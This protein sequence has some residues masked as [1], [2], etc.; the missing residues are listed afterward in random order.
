MI[1]LSGTATIAGDSTAA[2][3]DIATSGLGSLTV[4]TV[5][6]GTL[7]S[8]GLM[9][10]GGS[11]ALV[12]TNSGDIIVNQAVS[13]TD[14]PIQLIA[15][16]AV[17]HTSSGSLA[18]TG[19][20]AIIVNANAGA[21]TMVPGTTYSTVNQNAQLSA[22]TNVDLAQ[23]DVG[24]QDVFVNATTGQITRVGATVNLIGARGY[25]LAQ[26]GVGT[27]GNPLQTTL[28]EFQGRVAG[29]GDLYIVDTGALN[30]NA[31]SAPGNSI[32]TASGN[33]DIQ[34]ASGNLAII[35]PM[36]VGGMGNIHIIAANGNALINQAITA[37]SGTIS[38]T[39][40]TGVSHG[41]LGTVTVSSGTS[42]SVDISATVGDLMMNGA[43]KIITQGGD[44]SLFAQN[45][46][47]LAEIN[48]GTGGTVTA[49]AQTGAITDTT[50]ALLLPN[51]VTNEVVLQASSGIGSGTPGPTSTTDISVVTEFLTASTITGDIVISEAGKLNLKDISTQNGGSFLLEA[52][53]LVSQVPGSSLQIDG[54]L[55]IT[56]ARALTLATVQL[57]NSV[58][59]DLGLCI[60]AGNFT[61]DVGG[62]IMLQGNQF[63]ALNA[64][65]NPSGNFTPNTHQ[66]FHGGL[67]FVNGVDPDL[68]G[69]MI[70][71]T[72]G[73]PNFNLDLAV[74][75]ST[76]PVITINLQG[77]VD[78]FNNPHVFD[79]I[80]LT[81][82]G[83]TIMG[84]ITIETVD[85]VYAG[86]VTN[87]YNLVQGTLP[88]NLNS[89]QTLI[90]NAV[91]G[92][93]NPNVSGAL[94]SP[95]GGSSLNSGLGSNIN[96]PLANT[97]NGV[98]SIRDPNLCVFN[99]EGDPK[100][101]HV[102]NYNTLT[103]TAP[104][105]SI[106]TGSS[107]QNIRSS[108]N[109]VSL[110]ANGN[111]AIG[112]GVNALSTAGIPF[113][114]IV[115]SV[116]NGSI[117]GLGVSRGLGV[118]F[119]APAGS[120]NTQTQT[121]NCIFISQDQADITN[122][123]VTGNFGGSAAAGPLSIQQ[124][125]SGNLVINATTVNGVTRTGLTASNQTINLTN[126]AA[127]IFQ[128]AGSVNSGATGTVNL[129][130][131][132]GI[133][134]TGP[135]ATLQTIAQDVSALNSVSGEVRLE[136]R[137][138]GSNTLA[139]TVTLTNG[140]G[141]ANTGRHLYYSQVGGSSVDFQAISTNGTATLLAVQGTANMRFL[142]NV[143]LGSDIIAVANHNMEVGGVLLNL[144]GV[145][146]FVLD[147]ETLTSPGSGEF[148]NAGMFN[149]A[150][151]NLAIY[152]ASGPQPPTTAVV[153]PLNQ[154]VLGSLAALATWGQSLPAGLDSKYHTSYFAGGSY[155]G[156]GF[157]NNYTPGNGVFGSQVIWYK[158]DVD[159][160]PQNSSAARLPTSVPFN[161]LIGINA[162]EVDY[163][164]YFWNPDYLRF[165]YA[166]PSLMLIEEDFAE[167]PEVYQSIKSIIDQLRDS[168]K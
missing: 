83:N 75:L 154:V 113:G 133:T 156:P 24:T 15:N 119:S 158:F 97:V 21:L 122:N 138:N 121:S 89:G 73:G 93:T 79:A 85:P 108:G 160:L 104:T 61:A 129:G 78:S 84:T 105:G 81:E 16:G 152:A 76:D 35:Q 116:T 115:Y 9:A 37:N 33:V 128:S 127:A 5:T 80:T 7:T 38:I 18:T 36:Q 8:S 25:C 43:S 90:I 55:S 31:W 47:G 53:G 50:A 120:I 51:F 41:S 14:S 49:T 148:I 155:H 136:N 134:G 96:L 123:L 111:I 124:T 137:L 3:L 68:Q 71:A 150:S 103:L 30:L 46:L 117:T 110:S 153:N 168:S 74:P 163:F 131:V 34:T 107:A 139:S 147:Q 48:T 77:S 52:G 63:V 27:S 159:H 151:D 11:G 165:G 130:A 19:S 1:E 72:G 101:A 57:F 94:G 86:T 29:A 109:V 26:S 58:D 23:V 20:G 17:S 125:G 118:S 62:N 146:T 45:N 28:T 164:L 87:D 32:Q 88:F 126:T 82:T 161:P 140:T 98:V 40:G 100:F 22:F 166:S 91:R 2:S 10:G 167:E 54:N 145:G 106:T 144:H 4:D 157:G 39:G 70:N 69:A 60:V 135:S 102:N 95:F 12:T 142:A 42:G 149:I 44:V 64:N 65:Y 162:W 141:S 92:S 13:A 143:N 132:S 6:V 59:T 99:A 66:V 56:T 112:A 114:E 67:Y